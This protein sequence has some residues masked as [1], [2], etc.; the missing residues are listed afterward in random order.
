MHGSWWEKS[1]DSQQERGISHQALVDRGEVC[2]L[3]VFSDSAKREPVSRMA[4]CAGCATHKGFVCL[5][6]SA[7][8]KG[9]INLRSNFAS[10]T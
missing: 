7:H 8:I 2:S 3:V 9:L 6:K 1:P 4:F 5:G 10:H